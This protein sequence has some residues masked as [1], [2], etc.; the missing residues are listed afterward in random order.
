MHFPVRVTHVDQLKK[1][2]DHLFHID[3]ISQRIIEQLASNVR[4]SCPC[5]QRFIAEIINVTIPNPLINHERTALFIRQVLP[6][7]NLRGTALWPAVENGDRETA[8]AI[9]RDGPI[10]ETDR[11]MAVHKATELNNRPLVQD[12]LQSGKISVVHHI[13]SVKMAAELNRLG[14]LQDLLKQGPILDEHRGQIVRD[15]AGEGHFEVIKCLLQNGPIPDQ[16]RK[17]AIEAAGCHGHWL[18]VVLLA[19]DKKQWIE[20]CPSKLDRE[21][22][23]QLTQ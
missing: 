22:L 15:L 6:S 9:L 23:A 10:T 4:A 17:S 20:S 16:Y 11:G 3:C 19:C 5:C 8:Q 21:N 12:L 14:I 1:E 18:V 2:E 7:A 13:S